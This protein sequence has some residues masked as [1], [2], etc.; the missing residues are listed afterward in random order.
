MCSTSRNARASPHE[1]IGSCLRTKTESGVWLSD[2]DSNQDKSLQR[3][4]CYRYTIGQS[5]GKFIVLGRFCK[6]K[7][8]FYFVL[9]VILPPA[10]RTLSN[11]GRDVC[12]PAWFSIA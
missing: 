9:A 12:L 3:A 2:L 6:R 11:M 5:A 4:L 1:G 10:L 8:G 7:R